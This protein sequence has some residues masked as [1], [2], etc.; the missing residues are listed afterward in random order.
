MS[1]AEVRVASGYHSML[2]GM[3]LGTQVPEVGYL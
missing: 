1:F 3:N 2:F